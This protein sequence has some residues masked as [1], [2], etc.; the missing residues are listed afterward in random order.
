MHEREIALQAMDLAYHKY[1]EIMRNLEEGLKVSFPP[2]KMCYPTNLTANPV[3]P[4][5]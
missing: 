4:V 2:P 5:L 3:T 1:K